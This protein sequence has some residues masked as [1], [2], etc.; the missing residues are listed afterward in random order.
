MES[1][2]VNFVEETPEK[3]TSS[4]YM[5]SELMELSPLINPIHPMNE[6]FAQKE[7][8]SEQ[9]LPNSDNEYINSIQEVQIENDVS[10]YGKVLTGDQLNTAVK[11]NT[12][13]MKG[14]SLNWGRYLPQISKLLRT[15]TGIY[16]LTNASFTDMFMLSI[17]VDKY[18]D[19]KIQDKKLS[20]PHD[21]G[22][23]GIGTWSEMQRDYHNLR[24]LHKINI[25]EAV[26][27]NKKEEI[28][29]DWA[30]YKDKIIEFLSLPAQSFTKP[31]F[32]LD[33]TNFALAIAKWQ[34]SIYTNKKYVNGILNKGS[35]EQMFDILQRIYPD[36]KLDKILTE[37][38]LAT[39][40]LKAMDDL[41]DRIASKFLILFDKITLRIE[42]NSEP[43]SG[44]FYKI[45]NGA[46]T[47]ISMVARKTK[48]PEGYAV[49]ALATV[50]STVL[51]INEADSE[52][53]AKINTSETKY[54]LI[55]VIENLQEKFW[56]KADKNEIRS[57]L[58][59]QV[60]LLV[61][62]GNNREEALR[63]INKYIK[64][65]D[66]FNSNGKELK[67]LALSCIISEIAKTRL[68]ITCDNNLLPYA[69]YKISSS[70]I[71]EWRQ[72]D[73]K[74][75]SEHAQLNIEFG[76]A[77]PLVMNLMG[78][79]IT[80][81]EEKIL[82]SAWDVWKLEGYS[83]RELLSDK[84]IFF[85]VNLSVKDN[86]P[87]D[88]Y[89]KT[90][91]LK[92]QKWEP[93]QQIYLYPHDKTKIFFIPVYNKFF[94]GIIES[95]DFKLEPYYKGINES[96]KENVQYLKI[97][98]EIVN[99]VMERDYNQASNSKQII[100][101]ENEKEFSNKNDYNKEYSLQEF[102]SSETDQQENNSNYETAAYET[103]FENDEA[104]FEFDVP[105]VSIANPV[106]S[107]SCD[108]SIAVTQFEPLQRIKIDVDVLSPL[109]NKKAIEWNTTV[110]KKLNI[111]PQ[112]VL[113]DLQ[114]YVD[115]ATIKQTIDIYNKA[116]PSAPIA[117]GNSPVDAVFVEAVHQFQKKVFFDSSL[118]NGNPGK[119]T[120]HSLGI[121]SFPQNPEVNFY[122]KG[123]I[124]RLN[125]KLQLNGKEC[126]YTNWYNFTY[127]PSVFGIPFNRP[128][129]YVLIKQ[130][131]IAESYLFNL[132]RFKGDNLVD[133]GTKMGLSKDTEKHAGGRSGG[134]GM[135]T[136]GLAIDINHANNPFIGA[137]WIAVNSERT[138]MLEVL[139]KASGLKLYGSKIAQYLNHI[140]ETKGAD[141]NSV[142]DELK[143]RNDEF[144]T[145]LGSHP[146]ELSYWKKSRTFQ[147]GKAIN[148]FLN[149]D[150]D[151]VYALRQIG[152]LA[153]GAID[154][155][156]GDGGN[157]DIMH[158][159]MRALDIG[160]TINLKKSGNHGGDPLKTHPYLL[161]G[162]GEAKEINEDEDFHSEFEKENEHE[163][164]EL[165]QWEEDTENELE[166]EM[167][168]EGFVADVPIA[169]VR[170]RIDDYLD[171]SNSEYTLDDGT[172]VKAHSQFRYGWKGQSLTP[173]AAKELVIKTLRSSKAG[174]KFANENKVAIH[175]AAYGRAT[176]AQIKKITQALI[177]SGEFAKLRAVDSSSSDRQLI[178]KLQRKFGVGIDCAGYVQLAFINAYTGSDSDPAKTRKELGLQERRGDEDLS[179]L[180]SKHFKKLGIT[181]AR[182]GDLLI[183]KSRAGEIDNAGHT[184]IVVDHTNSGSKHSFIVDASWGTDMYGVNA[185]GIAR[186]TLFFDTDTKIW[187][188]KHPI[189]GTDVNENK[190]GPYGGHRFQGVYRPR[191][192]AADKEV[193][194]TGEYEFEEENE[195]EDSNETT[196]KW[197]EYE[198]DNSEFEFE[199][200]N[201]GNEEFEEADHEEFENEFESTNE[202]DQ[203][204][205]DAND[206]EFEQ[207]FEG[208]KSP[209]STGVTF[210][211][212]YNVDT[213][214]G[215]TG[216]LDVS[217]IKNR[218]LRTGVFIPSGYTQTGKA[219]I[220]IYLHGLYDFG[221]YK[222]GMA[223]YWKNYSNI[224]E[225]F[226]T[227]N[228]N[229]I[230]I[231]PA[232]GSDPQA[233][234]LVF[235][236]KNGLDQFVNNC[237][238]ELIGRN[239]LSAGS[240][241]N[242]IVLAAHSAGG[243]PMSAILRN[244]NALNANIDECWCFD[245]FYNYNW[246][247]V[248]E[249]NSGKPFYHYWAFTY[250]GKI[251]GP[252]VRGNEL[253]K[254]FSNLKN[255]EPAKGTHHREVIEYAWTNEINKRSKFALMNSGGAQV[256][257]ETDFENEFETSRESFSQHFDNEA[258]RSYNLT[259]RNAIAY[260]TLSGSKQ[261]QIKGAVTQKGR[262]GSIAVFQFRHELISP[263]DLA[264]GRSSGK[265]QYKPIMIMKE[266]DQAS[267]KLYNA[268][269][270]NE[271]FKEVVINFWKPNASGMEI[272]YYRL[273][274][275]N[276]S[277]ASLS[278]EMINGVSQA[279][280]RSPALE[281]VEFVFQSIEWTWLDKTQ[282]SA[283]D[284][285]G[286]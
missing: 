115:L 180:S 67:R 86:L 256:T 264:T 216:Y 58:I 32:P 54:T 175:Y 162:G 199:N 69:M 27:A 277:I 28:K 136:F 222:Y 280:M 260:L 278:Q 10:V 19:K 48:S 60:N 13:Y 46:L 246:E 238:K 89:V 197:N 81:N 148:G 195:F 73:I 64:L 157:G 146:A 173:E 71:S 183:L 66:D 185:G 6:M 112:H 215:I 144:K 233:S 141:T 254:R 225:H 129:H 248:L 2:F 178:R 259:S 263:R 273:K 250:S 33:D 284:N 240:T 258:P 18:Q 282:L 285:W 3:Y 30:K 29:E 15:S 110:F 84:Q 159:D 105:T 43:S 130:L 26:A 160:R 191:T 123:E 121:I 272:N 131:R 122:A 142:Y 149:L 50:V 91:M 174:A 171:L 209:E 143:Q 261:G 82:K 188:D 132:P 217:A 262:E 204:F 134:T 34:D 251:S 223:Y 83:P 224:R 36:L 181:D 211:N 150:R 114:R 249:K 126:N 14:D 31:H 47:I 243:F 203:E 111:D 7:S 63:N 8:G 127:N 257:N 76:K 100:Y 190:I 61:A 194:T 147:H 189:D 236:Y 276:V 201:Y 55:N 154:F 206:K 108:L 116:N 247:K 62:N 212:E 35:W 23:I 21:R 106:A 281:K 239:Q 152:N 93:Y 74:L 117:P 207:E 193:F 103:D 151:L 101:I 25:K 275:T 235:R 9:F 252:G 158:F 202:N 22:V 120:L 172:K 182:T 49:A 196:E 198:S 88:V 80:P 24:N 170:K 286:S 87:Y 96:N 271:V 11:L 140:G 59:A 39:N 244:E 228:R 227:G 145:Y 52:R 139:K 137:G 229:A 4:N 75:I 5:N 255:I 165:Y 241:V 102:E 237:I 97:I 186:R 283:T 99:A 219:D 220:I 269:T 51:K 109:K 12:Q 234:D 78:L 118:H 16:F 184:V 213:K 70:Y 245:C 192:S 164:V 221:S 79:D 187:W 267:V 133:M 125:I 40:L 179:S 77:T 45:L 90:L 119:N 226:Y 44:I 92:D 85:R 37:D 1:P 265:R 113:I 98:T 65:I 38:E 128:V 210:A 94:R 68:I 107:P 41:E 155:G 253:A 42:I 168:F 205:E 200:L 166:E 176:P 268:L 266:V 232:L 95:N 138:K 270:T 218:S 163:S 230:L 169:D 156:A 167:L 17:A 214:F 208:E 53:K 57:S 231:A 242:R 72:D 279:E 161:K 177:D 56:V 104:E 20:V 124:K 135:H 274:L 153:W